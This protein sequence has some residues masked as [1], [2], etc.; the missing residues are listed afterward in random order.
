MVVVS[1]AEEQSVVEHKPSAGRW[2][3]REVFVLSDLHIGDGSAKDN[4]LKGHNQTMLYNLLDK[5]ER[6]DGKLVILGDLFELWRYTPE[7]VFGR[8]EKLLDRLN[9]MDV[10]YVPGNHDLQLWRERAYWKRQHP[11]FGSLR[12]PFV[13]SIGGKDFKFMHGHEIDPMIS[14]GMGKLR[15]IL[16]MLAGSLEMRSGSCMVTSDIL[17]D[18][19]LEVGERI[20]DVWHRLTRQ[21]NRAVYEHLGFSEEG[22]RRLICPMRTRN[23]IA[24]FFQQQQGISDVT[25][26]GHTHHSGRFGDWYFNCGSWTQSVVNYL[27]I[28]PDGNVEVMDYLMQGEWVNQKAVL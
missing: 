20:L 6:A 27:R 18:A 19:Y 26:T 13:V 11:F 14:E 5:V 25:V 7:A 28:R 10:V 23:M 16:R 12:K 4:L 2:G 8:W 24:R 9:R 22:W 3:E 15:P 17:S 1:I 21:W